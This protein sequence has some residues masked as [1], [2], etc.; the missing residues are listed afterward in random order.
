M[1]DQSNFTTSKKEGYKALLETA[2]ACDWIL[3]G[4]QLIHF[5]Y[6]PHALPSDDL[7]ATFREELKEIIQEKLNQCL[8][9]IEWLEK[10]KEIW[11][12]VITET[13][14]PKPI[15]KQIAKTMAA[16]EYQEK[17]LILKWL[18]Y[19][20]RLSEKVFEKLIEKKVIEKFERFSDWEIQKAKEHPFEYLYAGEL[21]NSGSKLVGLCPFHNERTPSFFIFDNNT[22]HCF[23]CQWSGDTIKFLQELHELSFHQAVRRLL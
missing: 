22:A 3:R 8:K 16:A 12:E 20:L 9:R 7:I 13:E 5:R 17:Y 14:F 4:K 21:R 23:G 6:P 1:L 2:T 18:A 15:Y 19:W 11:A 10:E